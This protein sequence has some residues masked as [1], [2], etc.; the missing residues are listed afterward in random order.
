MRVFIE[1]QD[2]RTHAMLIA[3]PNSSPAGHA[4]E[5]AA[6]SSDVV[7]TRLWLE[8]HNWLYALL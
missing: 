3:M 8:E 7:E 2:T 5:G 1:L 4:S 6:D